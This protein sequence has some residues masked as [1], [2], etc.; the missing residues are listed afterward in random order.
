MVTGYTNTGLTCYMPPWSYTKCCTTIWGACA[1]DWHKTKAGKAYNTNGR[2]YTNMGCNC[3]SWAHSAGVPNTCPKGY[4]QS[5]VKCVRACMRVCACALACACL[6]ECIG[7]ATRT[8]RRA[9]QIRER[10]AIV[11]RTWQVGLDVH[12][13]P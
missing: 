6:C 13:S 4:F 1:C 9:I 11:V 8:A 7:A 12:T 10:P 5:I 2:T 3:Q